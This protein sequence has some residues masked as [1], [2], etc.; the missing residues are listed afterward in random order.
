ME[1]CNAVTDP[2]KTSGFAVGETQYHVFI[3]SV[4]TSLIINKHVQKQYSKREL[5]NFGSPQKRTERRLSHE[6]LR[7]LS[8]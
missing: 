1:T 4:H 8:I 5:F 2:C 6:L 3:N 7:L